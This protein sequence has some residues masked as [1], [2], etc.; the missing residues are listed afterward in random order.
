MGRCGSCQ[1]HDVIS[2]E[3]GQGLRGERKRNL[4]RAI[5]KSYKISPHP[6]RLYPYRFVR[7]DNVVKQHVMVSIAQNERII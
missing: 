2:I 1:N 3:Q 4:I 5:G 6:S 7:N